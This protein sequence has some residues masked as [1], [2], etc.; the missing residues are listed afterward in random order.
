MPHATEHELSQAMRSCIDECLGCYAVCE[1]TQ[2]HCIMMGGRHAD[3]QHLKALADCAKAC[4]T[5]ANFMLRMSD[6]HPQVC[7]VCAEACDRCTRP[8][9]EVDR[10]DETMR[11]C[12]EA[13]RR[14]GESCRR[15]AA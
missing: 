7:R 3:P 15:M 6:L 13:C 8:C 14:C 4:E 11:R 1:E 2:S 12:V 5:S 10:N 9:E